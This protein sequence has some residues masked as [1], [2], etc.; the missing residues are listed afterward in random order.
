MFLVFNG[1]TAGRFR[2]ARR[3]KIDDGLFDILV[4]ERRNPIAACANMVRHLFGGKPRAVRCMQS[5][6][7]EIHAEKSERTDVDGQPGPEFP[8]YIRCE[9]G[10]LK[11]RC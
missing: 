3:A 11:V 7:I 2:L 5:S 4:L 8:M 10:A 6:L 9:A 1:E